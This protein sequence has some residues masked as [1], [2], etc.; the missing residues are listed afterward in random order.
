MD[1]K[2]KEQLLKDPKVQEA[3]KNAGEAALKDPRVQE[4]VIKTCEEKY[5]EYATK[6]KSQVSAWAQDPATQ[7]KAKECAKSLALATVAAVAS[8]PGRFIDTIEQGPEGLRFLAFVG[9]CSSCLLAAS[10]A[11]NP[12]HLFAHPEGYILSFYQLLFSFTMIMFEMKPSWVNGVEFLGRWQD[13]V[14]DKARFAAES[15]GRG[16]FY[17]FQGTLWMVRVKDL[18]MIFTILVSVLLLLVGTLY[19]GMH[20]GV[21]PQHIA[22][23]AR[24]AV[25]RRRAVEE[26]GAAPEVTGSAS[27]SS[28]AGNGPSSASSQAGGSSSNSVAS[29]AKDV[30]LGGSRGS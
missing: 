12:L 25:S 10:T 26:D 13:I 17:F 20:Y 6:A 27:T 14:M 5:P 21:L 28:A 29:S 22:K 3:L 23:K 18:S 16:M 19:V 7:Q 15:L 4:Q 2:M 9:G 24:R 11:W 1:D 8:A 30:E